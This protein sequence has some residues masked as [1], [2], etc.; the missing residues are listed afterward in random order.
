MCGLRSEDNF[1]GDVGIKV[2][3]VYRYMSIK[4]T[5]D[6][7]CNWTYHQ[8]EHY[9]LLRYDRRLVVVFSPLPATFGKSEQWPE[10]L[11]QSVS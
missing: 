7:I 2:C 5:K 4:P 10:H 9:P 8:S 11:P 3:V 1:G 6:P